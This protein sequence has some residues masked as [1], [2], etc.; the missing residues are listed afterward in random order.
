MQRVVP[1]Q[2]QYSVSS[3]CS[4]Q[5]ATFASMVKRD[6]DPERS[7]VGEGEKGGRA[8]RHV[9]HRSFCARWVVVSGEWLGLAW[10]GLA[11]A[12]KAKHHRGRRWW[13]TCLAGCILKRRT[14][15]C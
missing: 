15:L 10:L 1:E 12:R 13:P 14:A 9:L 4:H 2:R 7:T 11:A 5:R 8:K 6:V 3:E